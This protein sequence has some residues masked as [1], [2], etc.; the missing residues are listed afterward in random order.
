MP[1]YRCKNYGGCA[2]A[3]RRDVIELPAGAPAVC[4]EPRCAKPL[5]AAPGAS[6]DPEPS[7]RRRVPILGGGVALLAAIAIAVWRLA[8]PSHAA[9]APVPATARPAPSPAQPADYDLVLTGSNTIGGIDGAT[10]TGL[11]R[12]LMLEFFKQRK[13]ATR[14]PHE[15]TLAV[16]RNGKEAKEYSLTFELP[17]GPIRVLIRPHGSGTA[18]EALKATDA[19]NHADI[20]MSSVEQPDLQRSFQESVIALDAVAIIVHP[21]NP[22]PELTL[23]ELKDIFGS[24]LSKTWADVGPPARRGEWRDLREIHTYGRNSDSGTTECMRVRTGIPKNLPTPFTGE[25]GREGFED[26][27]LVVDRVAANKHAI[28]YIGRAAVRPQGVR[29]VPIRAGAGSSAFAPSQTSIATMEYSMARELYFYSPRN[30][31]PLAKQFLDFC[32]SDDGQKVA[33]DAGFIGFQT[34]K[35]VDLKP[36]LGDHAPRALIDKVARWNGQVRIGFRFDSGRDEL[37]AFSNLNLSRLLKLL[38][39]PENRGRRLAIV[40]SVDSSGS[41]A[42]NLTHSIERATQFKALLAREG[43]TNPVAETLGFG[44]EYLLFDDH[45]DPSSLEAR[46]NRR[47]EV[48]FVDPPRQR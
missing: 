23:A 11:A 26:T 48:Y 44:K 31:R 4:P 7:R 43:A 29:V 2:K 36:N 20:G 3:D 10:G 15:Q 41:D 46:R 25:G 30:P 27:Q 8:L 18:G 1:Q 34:D 24:N 35:L 9:H 47:A 40:G 37:D 32:L 16:M 5:A 12:E 19:A 17:S 13:A 21:Q 33:S 22:I 6:V 42:I 38:D 14:P 39:L 45:G 28:G